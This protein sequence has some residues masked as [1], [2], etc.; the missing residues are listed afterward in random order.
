MRKITTIFILLLFAMSISLC[1]LVM[2]YFDEITVKQYNK[3][4]EV[5][6]ESICNTKINENNESYTE[7]KVI[8]VLEIDKL[9]IKA[10]IMEGTT[11][12]T[13]K[14]AVGHFLESNFW[15]GNVA[16]ASH[17]RGSFAH[18]FKD[19]NSL[20]KGDEIKYTTKLG[21]RVYSVQEKL[22]IIETNWNKVLEQKEENTLTLV[23]CITGKRQNR[24]C[25]KAIERKDINEN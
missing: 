2:K 20:E 22:E 21:C 12:E 7:D 15:N 25:I 13:L 14:Y 6:Y 18:Y 3:L 16:L 24:L 17:N 8:G 4:M 19:I 10:P 11:S 1:F 5:A 23:T 9:N